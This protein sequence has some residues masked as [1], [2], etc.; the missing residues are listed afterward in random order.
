MIDEV[1]A[2]FDEFGDDNP[3]RVRKAV[4]AEA[5]DGVAWVDM[6][7][8]RFACDFTGFVPRVGDTVQVVSIGHRHLLF[9]A[10]ALPGTG[11]VMTVSSGLA[12]VTTVAGEFTMPYVGTAPASGDLVGISWSE[13]PFVVGKL[14]VQPVGPAPVPNPGGATTRSATFLATDTGSTDRDKARWWTAQPQA[15]NTMY[16]AWFY[17]TQ[18]RDTIPASAQFVSLEFYVSWQYR[19]G[20]APRFALHD[21]GYKN[22][23]PNFGPYAQWDPPGGWQTPA[24]AAGWFAAL[25]AGGGML[26]VGLNQGGYNKFSSRAQDSMSGALRISWRS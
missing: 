15:G 25:K 3:T 22:G 4:F 21:F 12:K 6:G 20:G 5:R 1:E 13:T 7:G 17:G 8:S 10:R 18:I 14:S 9:A 16:G 24:D 23:L 2:W 19:S 26:G 11:T